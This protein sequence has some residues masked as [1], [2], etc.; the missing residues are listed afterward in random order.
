[1]RRRSAACPHE[2]WIRW[3][4]G[5]L[6]APSPIARDIRTDSGNRDICN[7]AALFY[8]IQPPSL[9]W[10]YSRVFFIEDPSVVFCVCPKYYFRSQTNRSCP[11]SIFYDW[12]HFKYMQG[13]GLVIRGF[14]Y[15]LSAL[16][17]LLQSARWEG[18]WVGSRIDPVNQNLGQRRWV[19]K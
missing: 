11:P 4:I 9:V 14:G 1:M 5:I 17:I 8:G 7:R 10:L 18:R 16:G 12:P 13:K 6:V 19:N 2:S 3:L 15:C